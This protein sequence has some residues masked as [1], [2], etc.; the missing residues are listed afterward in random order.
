MAHAQKPDFVSL[1]SGRVHLNPWGRQFSRLLAA[2]VCA[3]A[4]VMLDR[5][6][7]E[8]AWAYWLPTPFAEFPLHFHSRASPCATRFRT[9]SNKTYTNINILSLFIHK[10]PKCNILSTFHL[11]IYLY[12]PSKLIS[13]RNRSGCIPID[14]TPDLPNAV[15]IA[16]KPRLRETNTYEFFAFTT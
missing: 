6:R 15:E 13:A 12:H 16:M 10:P 3:S 4:V 1:R 2:E 9:S 7:S 5:P 14:S 8:V 11:Q